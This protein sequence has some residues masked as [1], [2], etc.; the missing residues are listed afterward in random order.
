[1]SRLETTLKWA[2]F[3]IVG[4]LL[5][6]AAGTCLVLRAS[7]PRTDGDVEVPGLAAGVEVTRDSLGIPVIRAGSLE[8]AVRAQGFVHAQDRFFQM[9]LSRRSAAGELAALFGRRALEADRRTRRRGRSRASAQRYLEALPDRGRAYVDA[10]TEGVNAGLRDLGARPPEYLLLRTRPERWRPEDC[11]LVWM[12][13]SATLSGDHTEWSGG[14]MRATLPPELV[15]FLTPEMSRFDAPMLVADGGPDG[16]YR[17]VRVP[18]PEVVDLGDRAPV[19]ERDRPVVS[20]RAGVGGSNAWAVAGGLTTGE[21]ALLA[22]DPHV[23]RGVPPYFYRTQ[24]HWGEHSAYGA[25][26]PGLPGISYGATESLAWGSTNAWTDQRDHVVVE[27]DPADS[28]RYRTP[29]GP[30]AFGTR[31][32]VIAVR[33][34]DP[35]TLEVRTTRWGPVSGRDW[36]DRPVVAK[37]A[38]MLPGAFVVPL[39]DLLVAG[40]VETAVEVLEELEGPSLVTVL[41]DADGRVGWVLTGAHPDRSGIDGSYPVSW[42]DTATGWDGMLSAAE[43]P[44]AV[45]PPGGRVYHGN[46]RPVGRDLFEEVRFLPVLRG[47]AQRIQALLGERTDLDEAS[48]ERMQTDLRSLVY[49]DVGDV[50]LEVIA[51]DDPDTLLR[52]VRG[53][54]EDW[55]GTGGSDQVGFRLLDAAFGAL[56]EESLAPLLVPAREADPEFTFPWGKSWEPVLRVLEERPPHLLPPPHESWDAFLRAVLRGVAVEVEEDAGTGG[57]DATW[58]EAKQVRHRHALGGLPVVGAWMNL[59]P[60][61]ASGNPTTVQARG[62]VVGQQLRLVVNPTQPERGR[63]HIPVGQSGHVLS[64]RYDHFHGSWVEKETRPLV[65]GPAE[66][67]FTLRPEE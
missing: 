67:S 64:P 12:A 26:V 51:A 31:R 8:D 57:V 60:S 28:S 38:G 47:R 58:G 41:A 16:G 22:S 11:V 42:A 9:D 52:R 18:G 66:S 54:V 35:D 10:Y 5:V 13:M 20:F 33:S 65:A 45:D 44:S 23:G 21:G 17:P 32:E 53:H 37:N 56:Y 1:M 61:P 3:G 7:L 40:S 63:L 34:G 43:L 62:P 30:A 27:V 49:D 59:D 15:D 39:M 6:A 55:D 50:V 29:E 48:F 46:N 4:L 25:S 36:Q 14:V 19:P 2:G 24:M